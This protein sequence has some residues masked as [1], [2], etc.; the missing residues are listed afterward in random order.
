M[1]FEVATLAQ[2]GLKFV[3]ANVVEAMSTQN[4]GW[5]YGRKWCAAALRWFDIELIF[6]ALTTM[7]FMF[8]LHFCYAAPGSCMNPWKV[9]LV[10]ADQLMKM[11]GSWLVFPCE[12]KWKNTNQFSAWCFFGDSMH[13]VLQTCNCLV[14]RGHTEWGTPLSSSWQWPSSGQ[15]LSIQ[16]HV[17]EPVGSFTSSEKLQRCLSVKMSSMFGFRRHS[18]F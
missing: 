16:S 7:F 15:H 10:E 11:L 17:F 2:L 6:F 14:F 5:S 9:K 4:F 12:P 3:F 18:S 8:F 13:V 1:Q